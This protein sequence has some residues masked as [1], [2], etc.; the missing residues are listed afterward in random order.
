MKKANFLAGNSR[1]ISQQLRS[2]LCH[3]PALGR[4][5]EPPL[6]IPV[7]IALGHYVR[8]RLHSLL[9]LSISFSPP[10]S[11]PTLQTLSIEIFPKSQ[12][13]SSL[14]SLKSAIPLHLLQDKIQT[15]YKSQ[16]CALIPVYHSR[17]LSHPPASEVLRS[18]V[19]HYPCSPE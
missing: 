1:V 13:W 5:A 18:Y 3:Y 7:T 17:L 15:P 2:L 16:S 11:L 6:S 8:P 9:L 10:P 14:L 12:I 4:L 19:M